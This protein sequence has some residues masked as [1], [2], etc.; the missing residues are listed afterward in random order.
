[1]AEKNRSLLL[2]EYRADRI[3]SALSDSLRESRSLT[4]EN[5]EE[6]ILGFGIYDLSGNAVKRFGSAPSFYN[7]PDDTSSISLFR[8]N[9][10][11]RTLIL[12]RKMGMLPGRMPN[13]MPGGMPGG[14]SDK[15]PRRMHRMMNLHMNP[16]QF[17]FLE[18]SA[19]GHLASQKVYGFALLAVPLFIALVVGTI[20]TLYRKNLTYREKLESQTRLAQ[21]GETARTLSHEIKNPLSAIRIRTGILKKTM[22]SDQL[23]DLQVIEEEVQHLTSLTDRIGDFLRD[24]VGSPELIDVHGFVQDLMTRFDQSVSY[25]KRFADN[26]SVQFDRE[27]LRSVL[28]NL[29][30]N[31]LESE[32]SESE[33]LGEAVVVRVS[34]TKGKVVISVLDR[35]EGISPEIRKRIYD[36]FYTS[37]TT[38]SGIGLAI[39]RRFVEAVGGSLTLSARNGGGTAAAVRLARV[40]NEN[41]G[42]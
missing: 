11:K 14:M 15:T 21:L 31:A 3:A 37:K 24:P 32:Q 12:I 1:M 39:S 5:L 17:L 41:T 26:V 8:F 6:E 42:R 34:A 25:E 4:L 19:E 27:R 33:Q 23:E 13:E 22:S 36:P 2:A 20:G 38:G 40:K 10:E 30:K 29:V 35:G 7:L 9:R 18:L 16:G 28:E